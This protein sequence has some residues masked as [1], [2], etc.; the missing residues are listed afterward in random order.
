MATIAPE[1]QD[2]AAWTA[3]TD[4]RRAEIIRT[5]LLFHPELEYVDSAVYVSKEEDPTAPAEVPPIATLRHQVSG[6]LFHLIPGGTFTIGMSKRQIKALRSIDLDTLTPDERCSIEI[7][8]KASEEE[9]D[10]IKQ[11]CV[12]PFL[13]ARFPLRATEAARILE[14]APDDPAVPRITELDEETDLAGFFTEEPDRKEIDTILRRAGFALPSEAQWE[15]ACRAGGDGLFWWGD[16]IPE[17]REWAEDIDDPEEVHRYSNRFGLV[18]MGAYLELCADVW[19]ESYVG[20]PTDG[21]A[22][23]EG[24]MEPDRWVARGGA[25]FS[26]PWQGVG[27]WMGMLS[28][29]RGNSDENM[30]GLAVR[31]VFPL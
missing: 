9:T 5:L 20:L 19:H 13:M 15:Y 6:V 7:I 1:L 22:W 29:A 28:A 8:I 18:N 16:R 25:A 4:T 31:P 3:A 12:P 23:R 14:L 17:Q 11:V 24:A 27:E 2:I 26:Y 21:S 30:I 10:Q